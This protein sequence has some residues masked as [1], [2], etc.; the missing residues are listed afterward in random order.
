MLLMLAGWLCQEA[1]QDCGCTSFSV[2][3][4]MACLTAAENQHDLVIIEC[5]IHHTVHVH[6]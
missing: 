3:E 5:G 1:E 2:V 4:G 6:W